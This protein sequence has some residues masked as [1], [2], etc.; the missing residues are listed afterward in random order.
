MEM[1]DEGNGWDGMYDDMGYTTGM[2]LA[3]VIHATLARPLEAHLTEWDAVDV[4]VT[5]AERETVR[6]NAR[7]TWMDL[8]LDAHTESFGAQ[9]LVDCNGERSHA[10]FKRFF[11]IPV[12]A[13]KRLGLESQ[14]AAMDKYPTFAQELALAPPSALILLVSSR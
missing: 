10:T 4:E 3:S 8:T 2:L 5:R 13:V 7:V 6:A 11:P 14:L 12:F 9:L 1:Y